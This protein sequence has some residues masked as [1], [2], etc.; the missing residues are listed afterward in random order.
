MTGANHGADRKRQRPVRRRRVRATLSRGELAG[1]AALAS[2]VVGSALAFG[3]QQTWALVSV[4]LVAALAAVL[5]RPA[6]NPRPAWFLVALATYTLCQII[7]LPFSWV[8]QLS[9]E[10]A[11]VWA[12]AFRTLA[13]PQRSFI[14]L[15]VDPAATALE[16]LKGF[17]YA[18]VLVAAC[19][20]RERRGPV[21]V[22][23]LVLGSA[24]AVG[25]VTLVHGIFDIQLIYGAYRPQELSQWLRG[26]FVNGNNL[27][28]YLNVGLFAGVGLW[29]TREKKLPAWTFALAV[30][31][32]AVHVLLTGS[33][34]GAASL[35]VGALF[36]GVAMARQRRFVSSRVVL[37]LGGACVL[38]FGI[39]F[40]I[41]G[42]GLLRAFGD[43]D[44]RAKVS[45]WKWS[46]ELIRDF[47]IFGA[48][49]GAFETAFQPYRQLLDRNWTMVFPYTEN[50]PLQWVTDWGIGVAGAVLVALGLMLG[51]VFARAWRDPLASCLAA[52]IGALLLQNLVDLALE[53]FA[54][55]ALALVALGGLTAP[56]P[57]SRPRVSSAFPAALGVVVGVLIVLATSAAPVQT[58][59]RH[60]ARAYSAWAR[61]G[62]RQPRAFLAEL[63]GAVLRHP[64]EAYFPLVASVVA[65]KVGDDPLRWIGR[66][67]DRSP[68]D[69]HAHL[70]LSEVLAR[71]QAYRQAL[72]HLRL[73]AL[74]D[75]VIRDAALGK[76]A[77]LAR[78]PG[79]LLSA[80]A[81][82]VPGG[83][84]LPEVCK[85]TVGV[86]RIECWREVSRRDAA[87]LGAKHE[88]A[89]ALLDALEG[90]AAPCAGESAR[91]CA[92]EVGSCLVALE[93]GSKD[94]RIKELRARER[95]F[96]GDTRG[97]AALLVEHC[98]GGKE[99]SPCRSR[100]I[101]LAAKVKDI[102]LLGAA[103]ERDLAAACGEPA[104]CASTHERVGTA[105]ER[106]GAVGLALKHFSAAATEEPSVNRWLRSAEVAARAGSA[107]STKV[108]LDRARREGA[109]SAEQQRRVEGIDAT[110]AGMSTSN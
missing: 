17:G 102:K 110:L 77:G 70:L 72:M 66:A 28:G 81:L 42:E 16:V 58:E 37:A 3:A 53:I 10:S 22:A 12:G 85:K 8:E 97:A 79:E 104:H 101:D 87:E 62:A 107:V 59:R 34:G 84:L 103:A 65:A 90:G 5:L 32:L 15:S 80:F 18:C 46:L 86:L 6:W 82:D 26:P 44:M 36:V 50:F 75:S 99:A 98:P 109:L 73:A 9:P 96:S 21:A 88:L 108:A 61:D 54:V 40:A 25:A 78:N 24:F 71:K 93:R 68:L 38:S 89:G 55:V 29:L 91:G 56:A 94:W 74:Y 49:R 48:G 60:V 14:P 33:R 100:A 23:L 47:P 13:L 76:A 45:A 95:A 35:L 64:A 92:S 20:L 57:A 30:P 11:A 51:G 1:V 83:S 63:R 27:A 31:L 19:G 52:G 41:A 2:A 106:V 69:G 7:P 67:L 4:T 105:Y 39:A 43:R